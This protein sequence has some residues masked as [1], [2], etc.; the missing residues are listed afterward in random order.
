[1]KEYHQGSIGIVETDLVGMKLLLENCDL[2][3]TV[4]T[5]IMHLGV[6][7]EIP[8]VAIVGATDPKVIL[9]DR[10]ERTYR[11]YASDIPLCDVQRLV[12]TVLNKVANERIC[13]GLLSRQ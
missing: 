10:V 4:N 3:V 13:N 2:L 12:D 6:A 11:E 1:M 8:M 7:L 9:P 5:F